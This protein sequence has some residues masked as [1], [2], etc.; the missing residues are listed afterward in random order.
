MSD[1][2]Q[3]ETLLDLAK[4][5]E[6]EK[7]SKTA[8]LSNLQIPER[9]FVNELGVNF[10]P[11]DKDG[12]ALAPVLICSAIY[13]DARTRDAEG[14]NHGRLLRF[15]DPD[16]K[17]HYWA[18]PMEILAGDGIEC[19]RNLLSMGVIINPNRQAKEKLIDYFSHSNP[20]EIVLCVSHIGWHN[21]IFVLPDKAIGETNGEKIIFQSLTTD[22]VGFKLK[23]GLEDWRTNISNYCR[24][25]TRLILAVSVAFAPP[26]LTLLNEESG[27]VHLNGASSTGKTTA[28]K[29]ACSVWGE[30]ERLQTWRT[31]SNGLEG[32]AAL[33]NDSLL[34]LDEMSQ[35][36]PKDAGEVAYML[37]NGVGKSRSKK[38]GSLQKKARWQLMFLSS[39]EI[40]LSEHISQTGK[41]SKAGQQVRLLDIPADAGQNI[42]IFEN[43]HGFNNGSELARHITQMTKHYYGH[44]IRE[45]LTMI[46]E[47]DIERLIHSIEGLRQD[48][49]NELKIESSDGQ[50]KRAANRFSLIAAA[51]ELATRLGITGW[52]QGEAFDALKKCFYDWLNNRGGLNSQEELQIISQVRGFFQANYPS[53]FL[54]WKDPNS[55]IISKAGFYKRDTNNEEIEFFVETEV[56]RTEIC[57][58][59]NPT[60]VS[61]VCIKLGWLVP[62]SL[63]RATSPHRAPDTNKPRRF[64]LF[65]Y[66]VL[67]DE[68]EG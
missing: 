3:D 9:F 6:E 47:G 20:K 43:L 36:D 11:L 51:G 44:P 19:R 49:I 13:V 23:G 37:A 25:N 7:E 60:L 58:G 55:K 65:N 50:V 40:G 59:F 31:T 61:K 14:L 5:Y 67:G 30:P 35:V 8:S 15:K 22:V 28:L 52:L 66:K 4:D 54:S 34:C 21:G 1:H 26:L 48:F 63:G 39:G 18:M 41:K 2:P 45:F 64:Y 46:T 57:K 42:G 38:D 24:G 53:Q 27:G 29:I 10:V 12:N 17:E 33:H 16:G 32:V 62:D 56:Y 68:Y